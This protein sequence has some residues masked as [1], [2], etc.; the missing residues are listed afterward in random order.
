M[1]AWLLRYNKKIDCYGGGGGKR[2]GERENQDNVFAKRT[3]EFWN[4]D[5]SFSPF[6]D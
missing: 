1:L 6:I 5:F 2:E 4:L 3:L